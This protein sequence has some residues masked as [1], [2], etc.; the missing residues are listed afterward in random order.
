MAR[1]EHLIGME[2][3][4]V[5]ATGLEQEG[6]LAMREETTEIDQHH[7]IALEGEFD[8]LHLTVTD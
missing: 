1:T 4:V 3:H 5:V 2:G 8:P 7:M 6:L